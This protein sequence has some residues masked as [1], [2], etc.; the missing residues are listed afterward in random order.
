M[1]KVKPLRVFRDFTQSPYRKKVSQYEFVFSSHFNKERFEKALASN[2]V[3]FKMR[4]KKLYDM[5]VLYNIVSVFALYKVVERRGFLVY[6]TPGN[7]TVPIYNA[8][9]V[10]IVADVRVLV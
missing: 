10:Q 3:H 4:C 9:V 8:D 6:Y 2:G 1:E 7:Y 5:D